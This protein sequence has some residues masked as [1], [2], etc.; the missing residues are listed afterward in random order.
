MGGDEG[1]EE[2]FEL[3]EVQE[4]M[5]GSDLLR[6]DA[7]GAIFAEPPEAPAFA[8]AADELEAAAQATATIAPEEAAAGD[9][10]YDLQTAQVGVVLRR[11]I[12]RAGTEAVDLDDVIPPQ[13]TEKATAARTF[14]ALLVLC[15][16]GDLRPVQTE[17]FGPITISLC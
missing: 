3:P 12:E 5:A 9:G 7:L 11:F 13:V 2:G 4:L 15:T 10:P 16:G 6:P 8:A 1:G 17:P 14:A